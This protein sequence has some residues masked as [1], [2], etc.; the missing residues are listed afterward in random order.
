MAHH[1]YA[2][3]RAKARQLAHAAVSRGE[4]LAWFEELYSQAES[5]GLSSIP[6]ADLEP[7]PSLVE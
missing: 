7:N 4:P 6:W 5:A 3:S 2:M 1:G